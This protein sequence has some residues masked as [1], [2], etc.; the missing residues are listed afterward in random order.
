[1]ISHSV[2]PVLQEGIK[3][4]V[5][6]KERGGQETERVRVIDW[7]QPANNDFRLVS[8][9][10]A[11]G[12]LYTCRPDLVGFVNGLPLEVVELKQPGAPTHERTSGIGVY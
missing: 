9:F 2:Y 5:A 10:T 6:D 3:L 4:S 7:E 8:Q 11:T 1:M 12:P